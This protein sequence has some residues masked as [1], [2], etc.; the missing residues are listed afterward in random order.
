MDA[1]TTHVPLSQ[2]TGKLADAAR[3]VLRALRWGQYLICEQR[4]PPEIPDHLLQR[5][6]MRSANS[7]N[8]PRSR[9]G[10]DA[11]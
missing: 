5:I 7:R 9:P 4:Q 8:Q 6:L 3:D 1:L 11:A 2:R 10:R